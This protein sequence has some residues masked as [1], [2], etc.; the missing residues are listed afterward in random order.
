MNEG[1]VSW[2]CSECYIAVLN[3][4]LRMGCSRIYVS[5]H[6][7]THLQLKR[8]AILV[9]GTGALV[10]GCLAGYAKYEAHSAQAAVVFLG[11]VLSEAN[12]ECG[13][14]RTSIYCELIDAKREDFHRSVAS[15][16]EH[17]EAATAF[18]GV[19]VSIPLIC[20]FLWFGGRWV[21]T[22]SARSRAKP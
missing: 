21:V 16:N 20:A 17:D 9:A 22:G 4:A 1:G 6:M 7:V 18:F 19:S 12:S 8:L 11:Q 15:R 14:D 3:V 10:F 2:R 5:G 13:K